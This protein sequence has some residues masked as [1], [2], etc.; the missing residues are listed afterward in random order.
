MNSVSLYF[1]ILFTLLSQFHELFSPPPR[2]AAGMKL[3]NVC[4]KSPN[5]PQSIDF[6]LVD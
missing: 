2:E 6:W 3:S 4:E 5:H 1:D